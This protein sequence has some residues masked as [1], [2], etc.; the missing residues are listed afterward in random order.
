MKLPFFIIPIIMATLSICF[1]K[2]PKEQSNI[3]SDKITWVQK[4]LEKELH[5]QK[6]IKWKAY[7]LK[8]LTTPAGT[9]FK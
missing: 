8:A 9:Y 5:Y 7:F 2:Y 1:G 3:F 6:M 4:S